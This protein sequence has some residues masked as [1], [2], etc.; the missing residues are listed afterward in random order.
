[1]VNKMNYRAIAALIV[2][3]ATLCSLGGCNVFTDLEA[4]RSDGP[5]DTCEIED[6]CDGCTARN[7]CGGCGTL[8]GDVGDGCG[9]CQSGTLACDGEALACQGDA[10]DAA[11]NECGGCMVLSGGVGDDCGI[12]GSGALRCDRKEAL[13]CEG[14]REDSR[15]ACG[16]CMALEGALGDA[17]GACE[18][19]EFACAE[20]NESL[21]CDGDLGDGARNACGGCEELAAE[22][23][24]PCMDG[25]GMYVCAEGAL[26]C[27]AQEPPIWYQDNDQDDF[28][29]PNAPTTQSCDQPADHVANADDCNDGAMDVNP[30][31]DEV[32][33]DGMD[34]DCDGFLAIVPG[35]FEQGS[36]PDE[37]GR[38][39]T[40]TRRHVD[41][42]RSLLVS[43]TEVTR[44]QWAS[45]VPNTPAPGDCDGED[46]PVACVNFYEAVYFLNRQSAGEG[47]TE[48]YTL[49]DCAGTP[50]TSVC[51]DQTAEVCTDNYVCAGVEFAGL[52]CDGYRL[53]TEAEGEYFTRAGTITGHYMGD[54]LAAENCNDP[55]I[56]RFAWWC[57]NGDNQTHRV[58]TK[59]SNPFGLH[60]TL[61]NVEE[62][63]GD[64]YAVRGGEPVTDP[65]VPAGDAQVVRGGSFRDVAG[66]IRSA[67]RGSEDAVCGSR[68]RGFRAVRTVPND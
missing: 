10:G 58:G 57:P 29:D 46:C 4:L 61:G 65:I 38:E 60:D 68:F 28:G 12:C 39:D 33:G 11:Q 19:G 2:T 59:R 17:C 55:Q 47:L 20:D 14:D 44:D 63:T 3:L 6:P 23:G 43:A 30:D 26:M 27:D 7:A 67:A 25:C 64:G 13:V 9:T 35:G 24:D 22:P 51:S 32:A 18:S 8:S 5:G 66:R 45:L 36:L 16:G 56:D 34:N 41:L 52:D 53:S 48:C 37:I 49:S 1:M 40:E 15:N 21:A 50:G 31:A 54:I 62:W 42:T